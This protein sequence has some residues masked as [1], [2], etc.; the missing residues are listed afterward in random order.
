[1]L[2]DLIIDGNFLLNRMVFTLHKN[3]ILFGSLN[4][5]LELSLTNYRKWYPFMNI[6][7]VSDSKEKSWRKKIKSTYKTNRK[8]DS[9]IDWDFVYNTYKD[10]KKEQQR[11][12]VKVFESPEIEGD[13]WISYI[14]EKSNESGRSTLVD[15]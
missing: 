2:C 14:V 12:G 11:R 1:M 5:S 10:F 7:L 9:T 3:N 8:K 6:Y 4:K 13:D 15:K